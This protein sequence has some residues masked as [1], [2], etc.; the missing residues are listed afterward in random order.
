LKKEILVLSWHPGSTSIQT[1][2]G[3]KRL[4]EIL[5]RGTDPIIVLDKYPS[6]YKDLEH[7]NLVVLEYGRIINF[8][9]LEKI[10]PLGFKV[11]DRVISPILLILHFVFRIPG[12]YLIYVPY[13]ELPHLSFAAVII[14]LLSGSKLIFCNLNVNT[15]Y[16]DLLVNRIFHSFADK[17][18]TISKDLQ[19]NLRKNGIIATSV[20][21]VGFDNSLYKNHKKMPKKYD[22]I[23]VGRHI[24]EKGIFDLLEIWNLLINN[25]K[26]KISL[27]TIGDVPVYLYDDLT[28]KIKEY[29][30]EKFITFKKNL[31]EDEKINH[32][33]QSKLCVFPSHQEG[34]GIVP[35]EA[36][37]AGIPVIL[38]DLLVYKESIGESRAVFKIK[39][40]NNEAFV[41]K[42][43]ELLKITDKYEKDA[44]KT[45][46]KNNWEEV[47]EREFAII[48]T[49]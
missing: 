4:Y 24:K 19:N 34:W 39:E 21:G 48:K 14:K 49:V 3:F 13:S 17:V 44:K 5:K 40:N 42:I 30:L 26:K 35:L 29:K 38:Y 27:V 20:N 43:I 28:Q 37:A 8:R 32:Y 45:V 36:L 46:E 12:K 6:I 47:A 18:L 1:A 23:F 7:D 15:I 22:A 31:T 11:L 25:F 16:L 33:F 9:F 10:I 2:G 41:Q